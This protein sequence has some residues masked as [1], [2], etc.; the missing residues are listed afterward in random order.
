[1]RGYFTWNLDL[2]AILSVMARSFSFFL[3]AR[4]LENVFL[5]AVRRLQGF[6]NAP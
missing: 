2:F 1:M 3:A 4:R 5:R 6:D